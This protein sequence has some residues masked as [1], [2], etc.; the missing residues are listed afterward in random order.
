VHYG[1]QTI[2]DRVA[3]LGGQVEV[4]STDPRGVRLEVSLPRTSHNRDGLAPVSGALRMLDT[5]ATKTPD[6]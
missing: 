4:E 6:L 2:R 5:E 1:L 3:L